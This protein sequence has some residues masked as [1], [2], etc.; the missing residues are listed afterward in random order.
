MNGYII[1]SMKSMTH[2]EKAKRLVDRAGIRSS[3][4]G[5]DRNLTRHGCAYGL[6]YS[7]SD[8]PRVRRILAENGLGYGDVLGG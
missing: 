6:E 4:V 2:A 3:I 1:S 5:L 8:A 7:V